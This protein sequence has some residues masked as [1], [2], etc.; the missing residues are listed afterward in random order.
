MFKPFQGQFLELENA[1]SNAA[2]IDLLRE[3]GITKKRKNVSTKS[4]QS[5]SQRVVTPSVDNIEGPRPTVPMREFKS[6][7]EKNVGKESGWRFLR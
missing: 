2:F 3:H 1:L 4:R 6:S 5:E 7:L